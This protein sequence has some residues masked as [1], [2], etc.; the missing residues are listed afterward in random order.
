MKVSVKAL[1]YRRGS[2]NVV[3]GSPPMLSRT[4]EILRLARGVSRARSLASYNGFE[5]IREGT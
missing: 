2:V 4:Y 5:Y 3:Q 1:P